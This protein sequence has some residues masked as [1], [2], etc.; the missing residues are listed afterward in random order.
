LQLNPNQPRALAFKGACL[1]KRFAWNEAE[2][3]LTKALSL[4]PRDPMVLELFA[5]VMDHAAMVA[6]ANAADLRSVDSWS[7]YYY[8]YYR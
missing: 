5:Q 7:D 2:V 8:I 3:L 6:A 1:M 4:S